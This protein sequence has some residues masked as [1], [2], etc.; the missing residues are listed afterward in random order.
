MYRSLRQLAQSS[1]NDKD[2]LELLG[3]NVEIV[4]VPERQEDRSRVSQTTSEARPVTTA[5]PS[6]TSALSQDM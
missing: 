2:A 6:K 5:R 4:K 3:V 1:G